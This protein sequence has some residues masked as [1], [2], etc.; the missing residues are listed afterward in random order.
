[1]VTKIIFW[2]LILSNNF[3]GV[4]MLQNFIC[5]IFLKATIYVVYCSLHVLNIL[6]KHS[7]IMYY[8]LLLHDIT[9]HYVY[10]IYKIY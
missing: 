10:N 5:K 4:E 1:M 3:F 2:Q 7:P 9:T 6:Y 8:V